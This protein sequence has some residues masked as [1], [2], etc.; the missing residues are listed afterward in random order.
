MRGF[1]YTSIIYVLNVS[2]LEIDI[3]IEEIE[4]KTGKTRYIML[5]ASRQVY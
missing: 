1:I 2:S 5:Y 3:T 4:Q